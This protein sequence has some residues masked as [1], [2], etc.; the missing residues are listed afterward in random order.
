VAALT[1]RA[2]ATLIL[3]VCASPLAAQRAAVF[4]EPWHWSYDAVRRLTVAGLTPPASDPAYTSMTVQHAHAV[5]RFARER[6][7]QTGRAD[8]GDQIRHYQRMLD[9][10]ADTSG[11]LAAAR[12]RGGWAA[13]SGEALGGDGYYPDEDWQGSQAVASTSEPALAASAHG[14][15]LPWAA[16]S[17]DAGRAGGE[18]RVHSGA[19]AL[20][21]GAF[22]GWAGRR[23]LDYALGYGGSTVLGGGVT[24]VPDLAFR[25]RYVFDGIGLQVRDPFHIP[26]LR[27][28]G[29][30]RAEVVGGRLPRNGNVDR[31]FVVFGRLM[32]TPFSSRL[33]L[34]IN[35]GAIFGGRDNDITAA[36]LLG[37]LTGLHGGEHGEFEN[38]V[39]SVLIRYR[40]PLGSIPLQAYL[41]W[42]MDDTAGAVKNAPAVI[43]GVEV[44]ALPGLAD[45]SVVLEHTR[46]PASC[47]G[48]PIWY[49]SVFFRGSWADEGRLFAHPLGGHGTEWLGR[50]RYDV[51]GPGVLAGATLFARRRGHE[52]LFA[53]DREGRTLGGSASIEYVRGRT[54]VRVD[55]GLEDAA[56]WSSHRVTV[57][58]TRILHRGDR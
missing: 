51:P 31:P 55:G 21:L 5:L 7:E 30:V 53:P 45:L 32:G 6:A 28:L 3:M 25:T 4:L 18:W 16:W 23:A 49:R 10:E 41:E 34:G 46:Y 56:T 52:N 50:V 11:P 58:F 42:G 12:L 2:A 13:A 24:S 44:A 27:F 9:M 1:A 43:A 40:P 26:Y 8:L 14:H 36:R 29:P 39:L 15:L 38:Q 19:L 17:L 54:S 35:R 48:N 57:M 22:D 20:R 47:C 33:T 37:L